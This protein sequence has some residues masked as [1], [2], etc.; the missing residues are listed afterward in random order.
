MSWAGT[1]KGREK[2]GAKASIRNYYKARRT[3]GDSGK[4][5]LLLYCN[6][7]RNDPSWY[8]AFA[9]EEMGDFGD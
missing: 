3:C 7:C 2:G 9:S 8:S 6:N 4:E 1:E 5:E